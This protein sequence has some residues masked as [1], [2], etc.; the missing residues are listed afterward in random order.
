MRELLLV[1]H[2]RSYYNIKATDYLN[3]EITD[4]GKVQAT[5]V[6][7]FIAKEFGNTFT[8]YTSPFVRCIQTAQIIQTYSGIGF[9]V[10]PE[11]SES[12]EGS[13]EIFVY[14]RDDYNFNWEYFQ[15][16]KCFKGERSD[17]YL[18][19]IYEAYYK[20]TA[21][22]SL[23]ISHGLPIM[24]LLDIIKD[25]ANK[26]PIWDF[27]IDNCSM[28]YIKDKRIIWHGRNLDHEAC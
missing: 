8:G 4:F 13:Q 20:I 24:T 5:N 12:L 7:K 22:K 14:K 17:A 23:V 9:T 2:A 28:T 11:L 3:S 10:L 6:G 16:P 26:V 25:R 18:N 1:R 21:E 15:E 27:S 19:R